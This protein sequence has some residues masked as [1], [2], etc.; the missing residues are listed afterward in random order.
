MSKPYTE[1][2]TSQGGK[3]SGFTLA[4]NCIIGDYCIQECVESLLLVCDEVVVSDGGSSDGTRELIERMADK[5]SRIRLVEYEWRFPKGDSKWFTN[6]INDARGHLKYP[7]MVQLDA[8][9]ILSD[10]KECHAAIRE[11]A[12]TGDALRVDRVNYW[13]SPAKP[14]AWVIPDGHCVG[15]WVVRVGPSKLWLPSDEPHHAGEL[16]ILDMAKTEGR[17][18]IHHVGFMRRKDAFYLKS[19][20][21]IE[22]FFTRWDQRLEF[23]QKEGR[24]LWETEAGK[25]YEHLLLPFT[26][27]QPDAVQRWLA[28]RGH[29]V[30]KYLPR[31]IREPDP[32]ITVERWDA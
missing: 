25:D 7:T 5:D 31:I 24:E 26:G 9:E 22:G 15:K 10:S 30:E 13:R 1:N 18:V 27:H 28:E 12:E 8:D 32:V 29:R 16:P 23:G 21:V 6:W 4:R 2:K 20:V 19:K 11:A 14:E 3:I 17:V